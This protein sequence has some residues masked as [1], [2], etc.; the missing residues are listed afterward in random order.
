MVEP[1][2]R[3]AANVKEPPIRQGVVFAEDDL[4]IPSVAYERGDLE[5][6]EGSYLLAPAG[7]CCR[8]QLFFIVLFYRRSEP[9]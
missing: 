2:R 1:K 6:G 4:T 3:L 5:A 7:K 9:S 8:H